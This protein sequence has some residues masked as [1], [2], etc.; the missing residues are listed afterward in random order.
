MSGSVIGTSLNF[1]FPGTYSKT[2]DRVIAP[3]VIASGSVDISPGDP[4]VLDS[5]GNYK[6]FA[7]AN[8]AADFVGITC[9]G[10]KQVTDFLNQNSSVYKAG[11]EVDALERGEISVICKTGTP[12]R[13]A[14]VYVRV[15]VGT[16]LAIGDLVATSDTTNTVELTNCRWGSGM[17]SNKV[18]SLCILNRVN[19]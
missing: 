3:G 14:K 6:R 19:P 18:A 12:K 7:A 16:G 5:D 9:R 4:L 17:D 15:A 8:V 13:G 2:P 11:Q 1:G 10:V